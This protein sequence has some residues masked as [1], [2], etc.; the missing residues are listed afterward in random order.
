MRTRAL[1]TFELPRYTFR[2]PLTCIHGWPP[3]AMI[4]DANEPLL[5]LPRYWKVGPNDNSAVFIRHR[6]SWIL[7]FAVSNS[8]NW[9]SLFREVGSVAWIETYPT[10]VN[11]WQLNQGIRFKVGFHFREP[12]GPYSFPNEQLD[13]VGAFPL[14]FQEV[15][16][17]GEG[18]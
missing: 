9:V 18:I 14:Q 1:S 7:K 12:C 8:G 5:K 3:L 4:L 15:E 10:S 17:Q 11:L 13:K 6:P 16:I 2:I